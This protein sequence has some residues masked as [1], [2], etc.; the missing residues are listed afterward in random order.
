MLKLHFIKCLNYKKKTVETFKKCLESNENFPCSLINVRKL[1]NFSFC[2][3]VE[4]FNF[5]EKKLQRNSL[6]NLQ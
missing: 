1:I 5:E 6:L 3:S 4:Y 2:P